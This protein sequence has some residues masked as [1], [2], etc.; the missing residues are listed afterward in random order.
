MSIYVHLVDVFPNLQRAL[1]REIATLECAHYC[2]QTGKPRAS[3]VHTV[4]SQVS[5]E[6]MVLLMEGSVRDHWQ[7]ALG[8]IVDL[9]LVYGIDC[10]IVTVVT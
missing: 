8:A 3:E 7:V 9:R 1:T 5:D 6:A 2:V 4:A 10:D